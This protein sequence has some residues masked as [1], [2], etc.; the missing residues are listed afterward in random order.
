VI[1]P[2]L[3]LVGFPQQF[4]GS[5]MGKQE[6]GIVGN[7]FFDRKVRYGMLDRRYLRSVLSVSDIF[8]SG[9]DPGQDSD[10]TS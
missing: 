1:T 6:A 9:T 4:A 10:M 7:V 2:V 3:L 8:G 5:V